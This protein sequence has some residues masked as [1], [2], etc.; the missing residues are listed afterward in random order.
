MT[1]YKS[2]MNFKATIKILISSGHS[3]NFVEKTYF[4]LENSI[5]NQR[6]VV[7]NGFVSGLFTVLFIPP[8]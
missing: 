3:P 7:I 2:F 1:N 4:C 5:I 6:K 8:R